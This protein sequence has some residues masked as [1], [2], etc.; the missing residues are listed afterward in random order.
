MGFSGSSLYCYLSGL[1]WRSIVEHLF[2]ALPCLLRP[3][4]LQ[5]PRHFVFCWTGSPSWSKKVHYGQRKKKKKVRPR[6]TMAVQ[7]AAFNFIPAKFQSSLSLALL[8]PS[9]PHPPTL[10]LYF[11]LHHTTH[12]TNT[13]LSLV[14]LFV[15]DYS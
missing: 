14:F 15:R 2:T 7:L 9:N 1:Q 13:H 12:P 10:P 6:L 4:S 8:T 3:I 5:P 11:T